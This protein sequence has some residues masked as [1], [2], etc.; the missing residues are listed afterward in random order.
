MKKLSL[1]SLLLVAAGATAAHGAIPA[2]P[3]V[4]PAFVVQAERQSASEQSIH[5]SLA[6]LRAQARTPVAIPVEL[7]A[8]KAN[9]AHAGKAFAA[10]RVAKS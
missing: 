8:F 5:E 10:V 6:A 4:L 3:V 2:E 1:L 9:V 7:P